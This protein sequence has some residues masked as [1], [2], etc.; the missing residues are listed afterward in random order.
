MPKEYRY[1]DLQTLITAIN[2]DE[3]IPPLSID[4][5][6]LSRRVWVGSVFRLENPEPPPEVWVAEKRS[7]VAKWLRAKGARGLGRHGPANV[8]RGGRE[9]DLKELS[10]LAVLWSPPDDDL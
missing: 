9:Y 5:Q 2:N 10:I 1:K 4:P 3:D 6:L 7:E 8:R